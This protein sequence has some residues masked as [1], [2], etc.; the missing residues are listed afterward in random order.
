MLNGS[1]TRGIRSRRVAELGLQEHLHDTRLLEVETLVD[2]QWNLQV[3]TDRSLSAT[4]KSETLLHD[5]SDQKMVDIR[6][7]VSN[8]SHGATLLGA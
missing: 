1:E 2:F 5:A 4:D 6:S 8:E 7:M 3:G